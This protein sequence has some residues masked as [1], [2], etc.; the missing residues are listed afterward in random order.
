MKYLLFLFL[1][2]CTM[3]ETTTIEG[4]GKALHHFKAHNGDICRHAWEYQCG[5][6]LYECTDGKEYFCE[7][8]VEAWE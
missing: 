1:I 6:H 8:E 2:G 3:D 4:K 5:I 7:H